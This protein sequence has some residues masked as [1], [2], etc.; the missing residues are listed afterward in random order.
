MR[1]ED[2][3]SISKLIWKERKIISCY[4]G[5]VASRVSPN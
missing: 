5:D 3:I 4:V 2:E 1:D